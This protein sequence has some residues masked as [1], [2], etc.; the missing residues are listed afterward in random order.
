[1]KSKIAFLTCASWEP[2]FILGARQV[3]SEQAFSEVV[4]FWFEEFNRRTKENR[5]LLR[6]EAHGSH[7]EEVSLPMYNA[8]DSKGGRRTPAYAVV[9][10]QV[11]KVIDRLREVSDSFVLDISTMPRELLWIALDLLSDAG[12]T[13]RIV[14]HRAKEHGDWCGTEPGRPHIVP[15]LGGLAVLDHPTHLLVVSGYDGDRSEQ[16]IS[17]FEPP[18]SL[19]LYQEFPDGMNEENREKNEGRHR[20]RFGTRGASVDLRG[21]NCYELDWG[22]SQIFEAAKQLGANANL[23]L[24]SLGP[25]TSAVSLYCVHRRLEASSLVYAPC[26][27]YNEAYSTGLRE[28]LWLGWDPSNI[29]G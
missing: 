8:R 26:H 13:G 10:K 21:V 25:K 6:K 2:R 28:S 7:F 22:Y 17:S 3:F 1:M 24:A 23:I 16:F 14:Y 9:W 5:G 29:D 27:D 18:C 15:K 11:R 4:C 20:E 12:K 19:I